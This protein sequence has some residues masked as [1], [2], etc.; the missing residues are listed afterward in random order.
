VS[1]QLNTTL[2]QPSP[3]ISENQVPSSTNYDLYPG[4]WYTTK[5]IMVIIKGRAMPWIPL[6]LFGQ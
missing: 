4:F 3:L 2:G 1:Y 5:P 6:L